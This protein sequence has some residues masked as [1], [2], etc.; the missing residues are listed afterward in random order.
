MKNRLKYLIFIL[1]TLLPLT[2]YGQ[3]TV[4]RNL[5]ISGVVYDSFNDPLP[6]VSIYIKN[7]PGVGTTTNSNGEFNLQVGINEVVVVGTDKMSETVSKFDEILKA[8]EE[9]LVQN[10]KLENELES[11]SHSVR[12]LGP[13][14]DEVTN[15]ADRLATLSQNN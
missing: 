9:T 6:G 12:E 4:N 10:N 15:E 3:R 2:S 7:A 13:V 11:F 14:F 5:Q 8:M 1:V